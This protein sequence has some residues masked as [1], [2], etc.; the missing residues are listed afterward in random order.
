MPKGKKKM[1]T[2]YL[3]QQHAENMKKKDLLGGERELYD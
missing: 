1:N 2:N 3:V